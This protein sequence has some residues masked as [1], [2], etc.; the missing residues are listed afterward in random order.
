VTAA[1]CRVDYPRYLLE[2]DARIIEPATAANVLTVGALAGE[3]APSLSQ[4]YERDIAP[5]PIAAP[6][7][8]S[9][10]TRSGP[11]VAGAVKPE[12]VEF[13]GNLS[14][15]FH[16]DRVIDDAGLGV[17]ALNW[18]YADGRMFSY[19]HGTSMAAPRVAYAAA[20]IFLE[21]PN[22][23]ANLVRAL[24]AHSAEMPAAS[25]PL[26]CEPSELHR[27][28]GYGIPN[29]ERALYST[30]SR[31]VMVAESEVTLDW[32]H[33]YEVPIPALFRDT[34]GVR[35]IVTTLAFDPPVRRLRADYTGNT[36][37]VR[38]I[39]GLDLSLVVELFRSRPADEKK[40]RVP[41][42]NLCDLQPG[43][44]KRNVG[45]LQKGTWTIRHSQALAYTE[46][47]YL[48]VT[49]ERGWQPDTDPPQRY[50]VV[51]SLEHLAAP[52]P[53]YETVRARTRIVE[54]LRQR[55]RA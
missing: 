37:S 6:S 30:D 38:L 40:P 55:A 15:D 23:S 39:R 45:T 26:A 31:A 32:F 41:N 24:L 11:G 13:G 44:T 27:L 10:F 33:V 12:L 52:V 50:A 49:N 47:F 48:V 53:L 1:S 5:T 18:K 28:Y 51:A 42:R 14:Y 4:R 35:R 17:V 20:R 22:A 9:P 16:F 34:P 7:Q 43:P 8:P 36:M 3:G 54:R 25:G 19:D 21:Y 2:P 46:P 29:V